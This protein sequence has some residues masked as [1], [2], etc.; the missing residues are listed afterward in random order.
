[1]SEIKTQALGRIEGASLLDVRAESVAQRGVDEVRAAV[2]AH[3]VGATLGVG[4]HRDAVA[5]VEGFLGGDAM[6]HQASHGIKGAAYVGEMLRARLVVEA[7]D[8]GH[9]AAGFGVDGSAIEHDFAAF[10]GF[11]FVDGAALGD[12]GFDEGV[13]GGG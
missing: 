5:Y 13:F 2:I 7:A 12:D 8:V 11:E 10:A 6:S 3:N 4:Y 9:L 1:M